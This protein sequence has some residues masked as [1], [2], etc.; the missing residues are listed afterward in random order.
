MVKV[1]LKYYEKLMKG[2]E[3]ERLR[4]EAAPPIF[5]IELRSATRG[6]TAASRR[7][8]KPPYVRLRLS[9]YSAERRR[10]SNCIHRHRQPPASLHAVG[11][12]RRSSGSR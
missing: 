5:C 11:S 12:K 3:I 8:L 7:M 10:A 1:R 4:A 2:C 9:Q 6:G